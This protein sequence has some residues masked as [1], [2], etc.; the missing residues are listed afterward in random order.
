[1]KLTGLAAQVV[2]AIMSI[3]RGPK[4]RHWYPQ[5]SEPAHTCHY[6]MRYD[7]DE[8][9]VTDPP[10]PGTKRRPRRPARF[11]GSA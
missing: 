9:E 1:M 5:H 2:K 4:F 11:S 10:C 8:V 3:V 6:C 7:Q